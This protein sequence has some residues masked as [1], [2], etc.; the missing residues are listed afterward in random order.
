M[1]RTAP[2]G[3]ILVEGVTYPLG[4]IEPIWG[5]FCW[6]T[7]PYSGRRFFN[8]ERGPDIAIVATPDHWHAMPTIDAVKSGA[9]VYVEKPIS[10]TLLEGRAMVNTARKLKRVVQVNTQRRSTAHFISARDF[11]KEG[12]LG[13]IGVVRAYCYFNMRPTGRFRSGHNVLVSGRP[14]VM[15]R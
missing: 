1:T 5:D 13:R 12:K 2:F 7:A 3:T 10:H 15:I 11:V 4:R 6:I 9:H 14:G 8:A